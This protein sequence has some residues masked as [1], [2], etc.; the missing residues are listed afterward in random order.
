MEKKIKKLVS[1]SERTN[2][3]IFRLMDKY[4]TTSYTEV[5]RRAVTELY[6]TEFPAYL[7]KST[8]MRIREKRLTEE[9]SFKTMPDEEYATKVLH[10]IILKDS[11]NTPYVIM[12]WFGN[13]LGAKPVLGCKDWFS[14]R[15]DIVENHHLLCKNTP[16]EEAIK[17]PYNIGFLKSAFDI[18][19]ENQ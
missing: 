15:M 14:T 10:G 5:I 11:T 12:H 19:V 3:Y 2:E 16:I 17:T 4:G 18:D 6:D 8:A 7:E 13:S 1:I 9:E